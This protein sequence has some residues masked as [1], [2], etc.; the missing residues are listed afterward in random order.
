M[1]DKLQNVKTEMDINLP[2]EKVWNALIPKVMVGVV[3]YKGKKYCRE[4]FEER[5]N[6]LTYENYIIETVNTTGYSGKSRDR[7]TQ[8]YNELLRRFFL[9]DCDYLFTLEAD[10][11]PPRYII[12][13]LMSHHKDV[14]GAI[15][16]IG[17]IKSR[18]PCAFTDKPFTVKNFKGEKLH[19]NLKAFEWTDIDGTVKLARGGCGLGCVL[20][21]RE[22]LE[23]VNKFR[24]GQAHC[25]TYF[26]EDLRNNKIDA[27]VDTGIICK[28][29][30]T[31]EE[32][33][34]VIAKQDF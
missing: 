14:I 7:I 2:S 4:E 3:T 16:P 9:T 25:D 23:I 31:W 6:K 5:A 13:A 18:Y 29:H 1:L 20:I 26:H 11:I 12:E 30:G 8:G 27:W 34:E 33:Q 32:W 28:H 24:Y 22:V 15:Y 17:S 21:K 19:V 10:V